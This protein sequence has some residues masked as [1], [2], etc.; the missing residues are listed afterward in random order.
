MLENDFFAGTVFGFE[1]PVPLMLFALFTGIAA[2]LF[3]DMM[4]L[5]V[6]LFGV[7]R[8]IIFFTDFFTVLSGY[9]FLFCCALNYNNGEIRWY[10][11]LFCAAG[12]KIYKYTLSSA[13]LKAIGFIYNIV[14]KALLYLLRLILKPIKLFESY[15]L[16]ANKKISN[17]C[18]K[19]QIKKS[20]KREKKKFAKAASAGFGLFMVLK[21]DDINDGEKKKWKTKGSVNSQPVQFF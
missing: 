16:K 13:V 2:G 21:N 1:N 5:T 15:I 20:Y 8:I 10:H 14:E 12:Y 4:S 9:L 18:R 3:F 19:Q 11:I 7:N 17:Y 6:K